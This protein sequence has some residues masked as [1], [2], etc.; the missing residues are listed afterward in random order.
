MEAFFD[1]QNTETPDF[2]KTAT[3]VES[4]EDVRVPKFASDALTI[5]DQTHL[6]ARQVFDK[7]LNDDGI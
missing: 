2:T 7:R 4:A 5:D 3:V 6:V 1:D